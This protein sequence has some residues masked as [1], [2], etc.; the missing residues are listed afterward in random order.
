MKK[1]K[2]EVIESVLRCV[3]VSAESNLEAKM[4]AMEKLE[5]WKNDELKEDLPETVGGMVMVAVEEVNDDASVLS[6]N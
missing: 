4:K 3:N 2:V 6:G 1:Y 5:Q